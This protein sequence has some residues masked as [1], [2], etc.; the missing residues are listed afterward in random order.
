MAQTLDDIR[1][2]AK[3]GKLKTST[4]HP[5]QS[6]RGTSDP[7]AALRSQIKSGTPGVKSTPDYTR[8]NVA[9]RLNRLE[10]IAGALLTGSPNAA[11]IQSSAAQIK[12][13]TEAARL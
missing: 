9:D 5:T 12:P 6:S 3:A 4:A 2:S 8:W 10:H 11:R 7:L 1:A 13:A